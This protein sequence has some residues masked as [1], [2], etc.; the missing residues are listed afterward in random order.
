MLN[1]Q[2]FI[3]VEYCREP[4]SFSL[5]G[6]RFIDASRYKKKKKLIVFPNEC[7]KLL[8]R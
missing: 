2:A 4:L 8:Q 6:N 3:L 5:V 7:K 1:H